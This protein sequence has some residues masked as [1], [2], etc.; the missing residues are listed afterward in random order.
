[1][2]KNLYIDHFRAMKNFDIPLG[3]ALTAIAGQNAT[4]KSTLLGIIGNTFQLPQKSGKTVLGN[5]FKTEFSE[6]LNGSKDKDTTGIIGK[7]AVD[8]I[9]ELNWICRPIFK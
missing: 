1:M 7:I 3:S 9:S 2:I 8:G 5:A 4:G 6:I